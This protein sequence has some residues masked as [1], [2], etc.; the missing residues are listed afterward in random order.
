MKSNDFSKIYTFIL[1]KL[2]IEVNLNIV[3]LKIN[4]H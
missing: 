4:N 2:M 1:L 3:I